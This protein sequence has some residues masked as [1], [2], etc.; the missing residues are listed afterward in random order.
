MEKMTTPGEVLKQLRYAQNLMMRDVEARTGGM[1]GKAVLSRIEN[2]QMP[3]LEQAS[4]YCQALGVSLDTLW[5][6]A[7]G[8]AAVADLQRVPLY[9]AEDLGKG[10]LDSLPPARM[11]RP[12]SG[13]SAKSFAVLISS[14]AMQTSAGRSIPE[15]Y[16][17]IVDPDQLVD[18]GDVGCFLPL[19]G[20]SA[21]IRVF[22]QEG[23]T[24][25]LWSYRPDMPPERADD[26]MPLGRVV[27]VQMEPVTALL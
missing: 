16:Y 25:S 14:A 5:R 10:D 13:V 4:A 7:S 6:L 2:G 8:Q 27:A 21:V 3:T 23:R 24:A 22:R 11:V 17:V 18:S 26:Y 20:G 9:R 12:S 15:G 1:L 19:A